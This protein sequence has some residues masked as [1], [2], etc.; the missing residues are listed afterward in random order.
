[1][2]E[3]QSSAHI[4]DSTYT[5]HSFVRFVVIL[6]FSAYIS[7]KIVI[8]QERWKERKRER[9]KCKPL[10]EKP[11]QKISNTKQQHQYQR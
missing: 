5:L 10:I 6:A 7:N 2:S 9:E 11:N 4:F 1:M 3:T 8:E